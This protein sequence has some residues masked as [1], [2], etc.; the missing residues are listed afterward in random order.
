MSRPL[1][2]FA[3]KTCLVTGA[4][5]GIGRALSAE[6]VRAGA[7]VT[8][9]D[10]DQ[11]QLEQACDAM[12]GTGS[13]TARVADVADA[14]GLQKV[15]AE[16]WEHHGG[17][18]FLFSNAGIATAGLAHEHTLDDWRRT[19][20]VNLMGVIHGF[21]AAYPLMRE[22][23]AGH[24]VNTASFA[25]LVPT[26]GIPAYCAT[27]AGVVSLSRVLRMEAAHVGVR[28]SVICPGVVD[29][30][31]LTG[32]THGRMR[33]GIAPAAMR[34][35]LRFLRPMAPERFARAV[36]RDVRRNRAIILAPR[37]WHLVWWLE[38]FSPGLTQFNGAMGFRLL[39]PVFLADR[40]P[41]PAH[42]GTPEEAH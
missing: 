18:D 22:R 6:L 9:V 24:I 42:A 32:G 41:D 30:P 14:Q 12:S 11:I 20:D 8:M 40:N 3:R 33:L 34:R 36:L 10:I 29:T 17:L 4:A 37:W 25:G 19:V 35:L 23:G 39:A 38:R 1:K 2:G 16:T 27:K 21:L 28:V 7:S 13:A 31:I 26:M 15:I 5:S